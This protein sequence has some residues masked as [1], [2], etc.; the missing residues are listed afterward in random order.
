VV[1]IVTD[2]KAQPY[3]LAVGMFFTFAG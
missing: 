2:R 3:S 1:G